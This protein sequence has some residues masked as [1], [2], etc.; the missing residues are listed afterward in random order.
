MRLKLIVLYL[1]SFIFST[2]PLVIT[3][4]LNKEEYITTPSDTFKLCIG[5]MIAVILIALKAVGKLKLPSGIVLYGIAFALSYLLEA[6]L[7]DL[8]LLSGMALLGEIIDAAIFKPLIARTNEKMNISKTADAT[9][10]QI[11]AVLDEYMGR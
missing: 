2:A 7:T 5:G 9:A 10:E 3:F 6:I 4:I 1:F 11:R 8:M